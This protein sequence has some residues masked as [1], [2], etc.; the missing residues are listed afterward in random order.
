MALQSF[1]TLS[2]PNFLSVTD[3]IARRSLPPCTTRPEDDRT[4]ILVFS[5]REPPNASSSAFVSREL[6]PNCTYFKS[7]QGA[8]D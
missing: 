3:T 8:R 4:V 7:R 2:F 1:P 5:T 6:G